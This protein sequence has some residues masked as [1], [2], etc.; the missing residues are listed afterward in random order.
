MKINNPKFK[1]EVK[2]ISTQCLNLK[3]PIRRL[4]NIFDTI[5]V[6]NQ[7][8]KVSPHHFW[9][10]F[11]EQGWEPE[12]FDNFKRNITKETT[13]IDLG[14]WV[15]VTSIWASVI[16]CKKIYAV[17][18]NPRSYA[19]LKKTISANQSLQEI[20][21][22]SNHCIS[23]VNGSIVKFGKKLSSTSR[24]TKGGHYSVKTITLKNYINAIGSLDNVF[25]KIDIEGAEEQILDDLNALKKS[26]QHLKI[27]LA[28]HPD[29]WKDKR[30]TCTALIEVCK[31][32][33]MSLPDGDPMTLSQLEEM[34]MTDEKF[35]H[36]GTSYGN[37][38]EI[39]LSS[40]G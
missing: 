17:E 37:F 20:I 8:F 3:I 32:F 39:M 2:R 9:K 14:A 13:F 1:R 26:I 30:S 35:P 21:S 15:G 6:S 40:D 28:L 33:K 18:A 25:L 10:E 7:R 22:L 34:V 36:W 24:I 31:E 27:F 16:G 4:F 12:T 38:F 29:F 5:K 23:N 19:L 11:K